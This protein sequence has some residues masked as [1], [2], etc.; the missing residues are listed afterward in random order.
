MKYGRI[1]GEVRYGHP[2][3]SSGPLDDGGGRVRPLSTHDLP[4][5]WTLLDRDPVAFVSIASTLA[6]AGDDPDRL[7][8]SLLGYFRDGELRSCLY[9]GA[10]IVPISADEPALRAFSSFI[11]RLPRSAR[12]LSGQAADVLGLWSHLEHDWGPARETRDDLVQMV[13]TAEPRACPDPRVRRVT[14]DEHEE[15]AQAM[16]EAF[17]EDLGVLPFPSGGRDGY[18]AALLSMVNGGRAFLAR[19][20]SGRIVFLAYVPIVREGICEIRGI[21]IPADLRGR[22]EC[23]SA[24]STVV[25]LCRESL[26]HTVTLVVSRSNLP[27]YHC[28]E[29]VGFVERGSFATVL[30]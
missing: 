22:A 24:L 23:A 25:A 11:A 27:A 3:D 15:F 21:W 17:V 20:D 14:S 16:I 10:T 1:H 13:T 7:G 4:H 19:D 6:L 28:Y 5:A 29:R 30:F 2:V 9:S 18:V 26:A 8:G 12:A